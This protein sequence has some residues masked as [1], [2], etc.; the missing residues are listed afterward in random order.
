M[1][2]KKNEMRPRKGVSIF[3]SYTFSLGSVNDISI[4]ADL[5]S[6]KDLYSV[7]KG[8]RVNLVLYILTLDSVNDTSTFYH[9]R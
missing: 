3:L 8:S 9:H 5:R 1:L 7:R 6:Y 2:I 4:S